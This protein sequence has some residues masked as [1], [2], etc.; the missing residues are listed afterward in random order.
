MKEIYEE[1]RQLGAEV[2]VISFSPPEFLTR[3]LESNPLPFPL[4]ADPE[5]LAYKGFGLER[6]TWKEMLRPA[7]LGRY[8]KLVVRGWL[9]WKSR[10]GDDLLQLGG[11]FVLDEPRRI[12]Y[13]H[14]STEPTDRPS[15]QTLLAAVRQAAAGQS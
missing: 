13:V 6:T 9:P 14:R 4:L 1:L 7:V 10:K 15:A 5:R 12:R 2:L 11:D 3:Y 8:L